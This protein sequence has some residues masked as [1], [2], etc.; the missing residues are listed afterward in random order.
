VPD[1]YKLT[2]F[3]DYLKIEI[4]IQR[5]LKANTKVAWWLGNHVLERPVQA[6]LGEFSDRRKADRMMPYGKDNPGMFLQQ[7]TY[8]LKTRTLDR[9]FDKTSHLV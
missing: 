7:A 1:A 2:P 8:Y 6:F 4:G 5:K 3:S 9:E